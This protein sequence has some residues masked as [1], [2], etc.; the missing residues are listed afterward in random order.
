[1][2]TIMDEIQPTI[3]SIADIIRERDQQV[4]AAVTA[5]TKA[6]PKRRGELRAEYTR[7]IFRIVREKE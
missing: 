3:L 5:A 4:E 6:N 1:M 7:R 2:T